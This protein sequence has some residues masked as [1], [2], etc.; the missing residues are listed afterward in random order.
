M[1]LWLTSLT[2]SADVARHTNADNGFTVG[3]AGTK[4]QARV[5]DAASSI[6]YTYEVH[7]LVHIVKIP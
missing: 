5:K 6:Y 1:T 4:F 2:K 7:E 3:I